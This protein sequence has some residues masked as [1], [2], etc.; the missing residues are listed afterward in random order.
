VLPIEIPKTVGK[1]KID[2][3][4]EKLKLGD[5]TLHFKSETPHLGLTRSS[6]DENRINIEE[7]IALTRR[8]LYSLI[9]TGVISCISLLLSDSSTISSAQVG[10][11][12]YVL[13]IEIPML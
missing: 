9:K 10:Q 7:R 1:R 3:V 6:S 13:P 4:A 5:N 8:T 2:R 11:P 12:A